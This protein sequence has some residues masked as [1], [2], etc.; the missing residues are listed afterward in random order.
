M[1]NPIFRSILI[2]ILFGVLAFVA[3]RLV[4]VLL[5]IAAIFKLSGKGKWKRR[6][7]REHKLAYVDSIRNMND[8]E[9]NNFKSNYGHGHCHPHHFDHKNR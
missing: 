2:G 3:F 7:W 4:L 6:Q 9:Y 1:K 5:I 8:E